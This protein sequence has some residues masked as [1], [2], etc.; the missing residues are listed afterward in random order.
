MSLGTRAALVPA[1][2]LFIAIDYALS[3][4]CSYGRTITYWETEEAEMAFVT[5]GVH[6]EAIMNL[7]TY[8]DDGRNVHWMVSPQ[9][10]PISLTQ[11]L[12]QLAPTLPAAP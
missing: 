10:L 7:R 3:E 5:S 11:A 1:L 12:E 2:A 9:E 6:L 8:G 4:K